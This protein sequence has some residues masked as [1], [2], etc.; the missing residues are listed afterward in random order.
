MLTGKKQALTFLHQHTPST[1]SRKLTM[2]DRHTSHQLGR[3]HQ[4]S[5]KADF[6]LLVETVCYG[7]WL[8][9]CLNSTFLFFFLSFLR[10]GQIMNYWYHSNKAIS[11]HYIWSF[12]HS[13]LLSPSPSVSFPSLPS[14]PLLFCDRWTSLKAA[15]MQLLG[16]KGTVKHYKL[17]IKTGLTTACHSLE[18]FCALDLWMWPYWTIPILNYSVS[19]AMLG[20]N[21][22]RH[23]KKT[24]WNKN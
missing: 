15:V 12:S 4:W 16:K 19:E 1:P 18:S 17:K 7:L 8:P 2:T 10:G 9:L 20:H 21:I 5:V 11:V 3:S 14:V 22:S 24:C 23:I 6:Q 13:A